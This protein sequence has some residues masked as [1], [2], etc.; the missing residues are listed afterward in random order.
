MH[1]PVGAGS[2]A[3]G[4]KAAPIDATSDLSE[5]HYPAGFSSL[6]ADHCSEGASPASCMRCISCAYRASKLTGD[7]IRAG[8]EPR[9]TRLSRVSRAYGNR[10]FGQNAP[11]VWLMEAAS[12][13]LIRK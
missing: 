11:R 12:R 3:K 9:V 5:Q 10:M 1:D 4:C 2:P 13:F 7:S 6:A 8:N